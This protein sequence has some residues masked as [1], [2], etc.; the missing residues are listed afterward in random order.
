MYSIQSRVN[1]KVEKK[2]RFKAAYMPI[3]VLESYLFMTIIL[4]HTWVV[5][6][7]IPNPV[8]MTLYV[9]VN[10]LA[11]GLGYFIY[12][13]KA[14][15]TL[16]CEY[17]FDNDLGSLKGK[18]KTLFN[19]SAL[20]NII[21]AV[22]YSYYFM[23]GISITNI[24][25]PGSSYVYRLTEF[26]GGR[27][28]VVQVF[29]YIWALSYFYYPLGVLY[30]T[31]LK[32][33]QK[34]LFIIST[35]MTILYW[36]NMGTMK[37]LGD[38]L[39]LFIPIYLIKKYIFCGK[40][41]PKAVFMLVI[42]FVMLFSVIG[43]GRATEIGIN[44][45]DLVYVSVAASPFIEQVDENNLVVKI[46][47]NKLSKS[48]TGLVGYTSQG[49]TGLAYAM[50]LPF[51]WTYGVGNSR[52]LT[53]YAEK[54]FDTSISNKTYLAR[55]EATY[56]WPNGMFWSTIF[57]WLA[58]DLSFFG[59]P[60]FMYLMGWLLAYC[61]F[62]F[63]YTKNSLALVAI[64]QLFI[65]VIFIPA[66]NQLVQSYQSLFGTVVLFAVYGLTRVRQSKAV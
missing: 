32:F 35:L 17:S 15:R 24:L 55:N 8:T 1:E 59:V 31:K 61:W 43:E 39:I 12:A 9:I 6:W 21:A 65:F 29:T 30:W 40:K 22:E 27:N 47:G 33:N 23:G 51:E 48:I 14:K 16:A 45:D 11:L 5:K 64:C 18:Q 2:N 36:L 3:V 28:L 37:G 7:F 52:T 19:I 25:S 46:L 56:S 44:T 49:Y 58:S 60:I 53:I 57:P 63:I 50:E 34:F 26:D 54:I 13:N 10:F 42:L 41:S 20:F 62:D 38:L 4:Y 66:N